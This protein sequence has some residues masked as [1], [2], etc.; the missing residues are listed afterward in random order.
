MGPWQSSI[1]RN[2][3]QAAEILRKELRRRTAQSRRDLQ[4]RWEVLSWKEAAA[5]LRM[6]ERTLRTYVADGR[7]SCC[8]IGPKR[9]VFLLSELNRLLE[10][11]MTPRRAAA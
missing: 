10:E 1:L 7:V 11:N 8:C 9:K 5:Y 4:S 3:R 6:S 2:M